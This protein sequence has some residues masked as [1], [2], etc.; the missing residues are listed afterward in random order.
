MKAWRASAS[1]GARLRFRR[2]GEG[3]LVLDRLLH[4]NSSFPSEHSCQLRRPALLIEGNYGAPAGAL[5]LRYSG[6]RT[7]QEIQRGRSRLTRPLPW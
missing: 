1:R 2:V 7:L 6:S 4:V 5:L 3:R